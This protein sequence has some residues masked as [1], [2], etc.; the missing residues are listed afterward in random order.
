MNLLNL[1]IFFTHQFLKT[2]DFF[3]FLAMLL[4]YKSICQKLSS[5]NDFI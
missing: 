2:I 5:L 1:K 3:N 4:F